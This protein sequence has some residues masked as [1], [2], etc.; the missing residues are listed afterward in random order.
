[1][2]SSS[3]PLDELT[4]REQEILRLLTQGLTNQEIA[5]Q[6]GLAERTVRFHLRNIYA[7]LNVRR[8]SG[9]VAW[10]LRNGYG[11]NT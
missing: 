10:A 2:Y 8:R 3:G 9:A 5:D 6:L 7:K 4:K 11:E 1:M